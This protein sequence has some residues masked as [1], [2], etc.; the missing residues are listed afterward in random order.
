[1]NEFGIETVRQ[2]FHKWN[3]VKVEV[4]VSFILCMF[5]FYLIKFLF[6]KQNKGGKLE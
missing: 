1:M 2:S 3:A 4:E 5:L 6:S